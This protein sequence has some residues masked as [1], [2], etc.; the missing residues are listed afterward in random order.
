MSSPGSVTADIYRW[1]GDGLEL[2]DYCDMAETSIVVADSWLTVNGRTLAIDLHRERFL[3]GAPTAG[4]F[5]DAAIAAVPRDGEWFPRVEAHSNGRLVF[6]LRSAPERTRSVTVITHQGPD[7]RTQPTVKGPD[8]DAMRRIRAEAQA[9]G[10]DEAVL[11]SGDGY[12]I[13]GSYSSL[14]WW[15]GSILCGPPA[16]LPRVAGVTARSLL[17]LASALG[18]ETFEEAVTPAELDGVELWSLN[19]L[20]GPRIVTAWFDG[21]SMAELPGRL[22]LWR[23]RL[24]ALAHPLP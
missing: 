23:S 2:L 16:D 10:A 13:E 21:P 5:W 7:E 8:L 24:D 1:T 3:S 19:A 9:A 4:E 6:R 11:L 22:Q 15:R 14:V 17:G 12:V 18:V 20:Q